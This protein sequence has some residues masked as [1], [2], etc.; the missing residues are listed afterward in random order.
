MSI[1]CGRAEVEWDSA[2]DE[3]ASVGHAAGRVGVGVERRW[4]AF[5]NHNHHEEREEKKKNDDDV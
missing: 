1:V 3:E 2:S 5:R 4:A